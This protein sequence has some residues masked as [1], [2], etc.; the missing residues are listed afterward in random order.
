[1]SADVAHAGGRFRRHAEPQAIC[2][3]DDWAFTPRYTEG[4]CP[5]CG[6]QAP[7]AEELA[8]RAGRDWF[9]PAIAVLLVVSVVMGVLVVLTYLRS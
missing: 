8:A 4:R 9:W 2:P 5:L 1:V 6:W 7:G 3:I